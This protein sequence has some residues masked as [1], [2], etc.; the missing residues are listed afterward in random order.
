[1]QRKKT[2]LLKITIATLVLCVGFNSTTSLATTTDPYLVTTAK[3]S[4]QWKDTKDQRVTTGKWTDFSNSKG[5]NSFNLNGKRTLFFA[6][7][8]LN[9]TKRPKYVKIRLAR[10]KPDGTRDTTG[11]TTWSFNKNTTRDWQGSTWWESKT[12]HPIVAQF[13]VVGGNCYSDQRQF[14][15]WQP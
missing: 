5:S 14:K 4:G 12:K 15:W 2:N 7:L 13:K 1:V 11:T 9:C 10:L 6:Q 8:H 3:T